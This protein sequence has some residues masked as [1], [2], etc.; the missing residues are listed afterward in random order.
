MAARVRQLRHAAARAGRAA[1]HDRHQA[2]GGAPDRRAGRRRAVQGGPRDLPRAAPR[3]GQAVAVHRRRGRRRAPPDRVRR[4]QLRR[5]RHGRRGAARRHAAGRHRA[6]GG[7]AARGGVARHDAV[8]ER[9]GA[10]GRPRWPDAAGGRPGAGHAAVS[11]AADRRRGARV[12]DHV[13]PAGLPVGVRH[14]PRGVSVAGRRPRALAGPRTG[15]VGRRLG[16]LVGDG[17]HRRA[18]PVPAL[19]G[20]RLH[21]RQGRPLAAVAEGAGRGR[22]HAP[23]LERRGHHQLRDAVRRRA[24]TRLRS[25]QG[26]RTR[27]HRATGR[28]R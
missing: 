4:D 10:V 26:D 23:D 19:G 25:G 24:H 6:A 3:R 15:C 20:A 18:R 21:R 16:R 2:G 12:R 14:R 27:D 9:A 5:R 22:R 28:R 13:E 8:G 7:E 17:A 11:G 1:E